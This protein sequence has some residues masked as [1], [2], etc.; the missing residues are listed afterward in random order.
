MT[1]HN[2]KLGYRLLVCLLAAGLPL[3]DVSAAEEDDA[4]S[5]LNSLR[6][7]AGI[8]TVLTAEPDLITAA[9]AHS[10]YL[11]LHNVFGHNEDANLAGF[12]GVWAHDRAVAAGYASRVVSE[13]VAAGQQ[14]A[15]ESVDD[16]MTAIYHRLGFLNV[17]I[18]R[19]GIGFVLDAES[20]ATRGYF[21]TYNMANGGVTTLCQGPAGSGAGS[22]VVG[23][24]ADAA[25]PIAAGDYDAALATVAAAS[26]EVIRWPPS[27][28]VDIPPVFFEE[29]PD[30]LP[31]YSVSG[32]PISLLFNDH[33]VATAGLSSLRLYEDVT[34]VE[35]TDTRLLDQF[36]DPNGSFDAYEFALFPLQRLAWNTRYRVEAQIVQDGVPGNLQWTFTT[37]DLG[38]P[39]HQIVGNGDVIDV[40]TGQEVAVYVVPQSGQSAL[41]AV[42]W[43]YPD[44][45]FAPQVTFVDANTL[46]VIYPDP[47]DGNQADFSAGIYSFGIRIDNSAVKADGDLA[48]LGNLDGKVTVADALIALRYALA[49]IT[50]VT[51]AVLDHGD[52]AP[53]GAPDGK[54]TVADALVI[55]RVALRL[56]TL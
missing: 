53:K 25:K 45:N 29:S 9:E 43:G 36:T 46:K 6:S 27:G 3:A 4:L 56:D 16:L 11:E 21:S 22:F 18:D 10:A 20:P 52:V 51:Q 44:G 14:S 39:T 31:D 47:V 40:K 41:G 5:Y 2:R 50:P 35:I 54:M 12:T 17:E 49:L 19:I 33:R 42:S 48:P 28:A 1:I 30:P 38:V 23:A 8:S 34:G 13:N 26:P 24:C 55:L 15:Q 32:N 7:A 37:R